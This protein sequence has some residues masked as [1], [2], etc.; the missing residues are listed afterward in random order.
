[1]TFGSFLLFHIE[2]SLLAS[3]SFTQGLLP[4]FPKGFYLVSPRASTPYTEECEGLADGN[5]AVKERSSEYKLRVNDLEGT[6]VQMQR[7]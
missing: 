1:M 5:T 7:Q 2:K 6:V 4:R 3:T